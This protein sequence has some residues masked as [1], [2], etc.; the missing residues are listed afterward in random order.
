LLE[1][2]DVDVVHI[3]TPNALHA[4]AAEM[5]LEAGKHVVCEKPLATTVED[6]QRLRALA[7]KIGRVATVPFIYRYY[8]LVREVRERISRNEAGVLHLLHGSYLQDW[9]SGTQ[10]FSWRVQSALTGVSRAFADIGVHW[11]DLLEFTTGHRIARV[12]SRLVR[13]VEEREHEHKKVSVDTEDAALVLFET[14]GGAVGS[15]IGSQVSLGRKNQLRFSWDGSLASYV[16]DQEQPE[17][18]WVG[19]REESKLVLRGSDALSE[20]ARRYVTVPAGHPQGYQDCFNAFIADTYLA[21]RGESPPGLP[22]FADGVRAAQV[23]DAVIKSAALG[24]WVE[25]GS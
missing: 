16:F 20:A 9:L 24:T 3:C 22:V 1:N 19:G 5:A 15:F 14:D 7:D 12:S 13:T 11:C 23:T 6:A 17:S 10:D 18:L 21:V 8:P 4:A 2:G 25:V